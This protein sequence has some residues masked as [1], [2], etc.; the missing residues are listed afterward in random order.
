MSRT[1]VRHPDKAISTGAYSAGILCDGWLYVSGQAALDQKTGDVVGA[2]IEEQTSLTLGSI[3]K[4]LLEGGCSLEDVVKC[5]CYL[6]RIEDFDRF[7]QEYSRH[8]RIPPARTTIQAGLGSGL[9]VEIDAI[10][11]VPLQ[12]N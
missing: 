10:A 5:T 12:R 1:V 8:F 2:N 3:E 6:A 11:R 7:D 9:L 4:V